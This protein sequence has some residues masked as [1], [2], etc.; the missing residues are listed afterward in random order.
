MRQPTQTIYKRPP[1]SKFIL[2]N[3]VLSVVLFVIVYKTWIEPQY[4][5]QIGIHYLYTFLAMLITG[6][7]SKAISSLI[8]HY[9]G[10]SFAPIENY[11]NL[12]GALIYAILIVMGVIKSIF[13]MYPLFSITETSV[14]LLL[15]IIKIADYVGSDFIVRNF[16]IK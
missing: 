12:F 5:G 4:I 2:V 7:L 16:L 3:M 15:F 11:R 10:I 9:N 8:T 13:D 14:A 1:Q 6:Y